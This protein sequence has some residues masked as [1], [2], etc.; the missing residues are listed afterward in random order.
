[1]I[2]YIDIYILN[3]YTI[4]YSYENYMKTNCNLEDIMRTRLSDRVLPNYTKEEEIF[5]FVSHI[6][7]GAIG[8]VATVMCIIIAAMHGNAY[9]VVT[10]SIYGASM[11]LL[12]T[13]SSIYH[14]LRP[15]MAKKV[16]QILD[17]CSI[18]I[19]IAGTYT[20]IALCAIRK[21]SPTAAWWI[22]GIEWALASI[23]I[24]FNAIDIKKYQI[25]SMICNLGMGWAVVFIY[26]IAL[27]AMGF[28][29][30]ML[31]LAGGIAYTV[32]AVLYGIGKKKRYMHGLF[33]IFVLIGSLFHL[34]AIVCIL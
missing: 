22:F 34:A 28:S 9:G 25:L 15:G 18:Y 2:K 5:N 32:G 13:M 8:I 30:M 4:T 14:G 1:M 12:Y 7:G 20:P 17:H 19:L 31:V 26:N 27:E 6:V 16:F 33:H 23:A 24:V 29:N 10:S 11:I 21:V 3:E